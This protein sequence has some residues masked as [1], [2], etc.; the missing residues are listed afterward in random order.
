[1]QPYEA[2]RF[3]LRPRFTLEPVRAAPSWLRSNPCQCTRAPHCR[4]VSNNA[5]HKLPECV[6]NMSSLEELHAPPEARTRD[7]PRRERWCRRNAE[8]N[9]L[10]ALPDLASCTKLL[11][12]CVPPLRSTVGHVPLWS[13]GFALVRGRLV[14]HNRLHDLRGLPPTLQRLC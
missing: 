9:E 6:C 3:D 4:D 5:L 7:W 13:G 10:Q 1:M 14:G 8:H 2:P 11:Y 12:V